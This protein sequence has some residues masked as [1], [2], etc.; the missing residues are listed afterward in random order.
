M[1]G[2]TRILFVV[3][4][5]IATVGGGSLLLR[6]GSAPAPSIR[7]VPIASIPAP[8]T[9][10]LSRG[11]TPAPSTSPGIWPGP[12]HLGVG[13]PIVALPVDGLTRFSVVV[14]DARDI[15]VGGAD[16]IGVQASRQWRIGLAAKPPKATVLTAQSTVISYGF[17]FD[18]NGD[19]VADLLFGI[20]NDAPRPGDFRVWVTDLATGATKEQVGP[21]YGT[22]LEFEHPDDQTPGDGPSSQIPSVTLH[23]LTGGPVSQNK[24]ARFYARSS[25]AVDGRVVAWD[26]APDA[27][28][29][30]PVE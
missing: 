13:A 28:W 30:D 5:L 23:Y 10:P 15:R 18:R 21:P 22:P 7:T 19:D 1:S 14:P 8:S 9:S 3:G 12:L 17:V 6:G 2:P 20:A 11:S 26:Y 16:I 25:V 24:N 29:L 4:V 27:A